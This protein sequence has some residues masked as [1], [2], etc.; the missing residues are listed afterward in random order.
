MNRKSTAAVVL[1]ALLACL[2][3]FLLRDSSATGPSEARL[4]VYG[5][6]N[7]DPASSDSTPTDSLDPFGV[8]AAHNNDT[9]PLDNANSPDAASQDDSVAESSDDPD[10]TGYWI[11]G[12]VV[13]DD[14]TPFPGATIELLDNRGPLFTKAALEMIQRVT[15]SVDPIATTRSVGGG[16]FRIA[17]PGPG[18]YDVRTSARGWVGSIDTAQLTSREREVALWIAIYPG[19]SIAGVLQDD[20]GRGISGS[21]LV[22][23]EKAQDR[24]RRYHRHVAVSTAGGRFRFDGLSLQRY[25]LMAKTAAG[26][27]K[28]VPQVVPPSENLTVRM[29]RP[30][31]VEG[32]VTDSATEQPIAGALVSGLNPLSWDQATTDADGRFLLNLAGADA[33]VLVVHDQYAQSKRRVRLSGD[34][35]HTFQ[36]DPATPFEGRVVFPD[37]APAA[38]ATVGFFQSTSW[39]ADVRTAT[40]DSNGRYVLPMAGSGSV[41][42]RVPGWA[43]TPPFDAGRSNLVLSPAHTLQG[44]VLAPDGSPVP[45]AYLRLH[46]AAS[47]PETATWIEWLRGVQEGWTDDRGEFSIPDVVAIGSYEL[48]IVHDHFAEHRHR[49]GSI[50][51]APIEVS[52]ARGGSLTVTLVTPDGSRPAG[53]IVAEFPS[54]PPVRRRHDATLEGGAMFVIPSDGVVQMGNVPAGQVTFY[55]R[56]LPFLEE[57]VV[58]TVR[59]DEVISRE[60]LLR[61][62]RDVSIR[63]TAPAGKSTAGIPVTLTPVRRAAPGNAAADNRRSRTARSAGDGIVQ[64]HSVVP[65]EYRVSAQQRIPGDGADSDELLHGSTTIAIDEG[66]NELRTDLRLELQILPAM[67]FPDGFVLPGGGSLEG[68]VIPEGDVQPAGNG[69]GSE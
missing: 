30:V 40:A 12:N 45:S 64:L 43:P 58:V 46:P 29:D 6:A 69:P 37:G 8:G 51:D 22:L 2:V 54:G 23:L 44:V 66:D 41:L 5:S 56:A 4:D 14:G 3:L 18:R 36:M 33:D 47:N 38:G 25:I 26:M 20:R 67:N 42:A 1:T 52:L 27:T 34:E 28:L 62:G 61:R 13:S 63:L 32:V 19:L 49:I 53:V 11:T 39:L 68:L 17:A 50:G 16:S 35:E 21:T 24:T 48:E 65:G 55:V 31:A 60:V 7:N 10:D 9:D 57:Q 59:E 15:E